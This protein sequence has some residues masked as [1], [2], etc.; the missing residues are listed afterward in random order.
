M[1]FT[2]FKDIDQDKLFNHCYNRLND[3]GHL[4]L[5]VV[6]PDFNPG[7]TYPYW[8]RKS[9]SDLIEFTMKRNLILENISNKCYPKL[10]GYFRKV[11]A[12]L[13][14]DYEMK[15]WRIT[16]MKKG[17]DIYRKYIHMFNPRL[18]RG[19]KVIDIGCGPFGGICSKIE[20]VKEKVGLDTL[21]NEFGTLYK[22]ISDIKMV[23][24]NS[25]SIPYPDNYFDAV[26]C[27]NVLDHTINPEK[28][29]KEMHRILKPGGKLYLHVHIRE[30]EQLNIGHPYLIGRNLLL[31][32][33]DNIFGMKTDR[34]DFVNEIDIINGDPY[35]T[36]M[37]RYPK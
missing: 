12:M 21:K 9:E 19:S 36:L 23:Q 33:L 32:W 22:P 20:S 28:S 15:Y 11:H 18:T 25:E 1:G 2:Y 35:I 3:G 13:K 6:H 29:L 5:D 37:G 16:G 34:L 17:S 30:K 24:G 4:I 7:K 31:K 26:F 10:I 27:T 14:S 8:N